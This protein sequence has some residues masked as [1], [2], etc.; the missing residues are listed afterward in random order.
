M[1]R[2]PTSDRVIAAALLATACSP[3]AP[4]PARPRT[5]AAALAV[6]DAGEGATVFRRCAAC[7]SIGRDAP[8]RDGPNLYGVVGRG[9][10]QASRR[11]SYTAVLRHAGGSWSAARLDAWLENPRKFAPGTSMGFAGLPDPAD[12]ANVIA[13]LNEHGSHVRLTAS[14]ER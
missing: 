9:V 12:R 3:D 11:F 6:A 2:R 14:G 10:A 8:D 13:Y 4:P 1:T 5:F 7:H